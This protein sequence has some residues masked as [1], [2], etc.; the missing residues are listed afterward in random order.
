MPKKT[1]AVKTGNVARCKLETQLKH[2]IST[3]AAIAS[4]DRA[5]TLLLFL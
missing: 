4:A 5:S 2:Q 3:S 1:L